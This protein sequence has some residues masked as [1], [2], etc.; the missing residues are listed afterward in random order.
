MTW[1]ELPGL[2]VS[3]SREL[4]HVDSSDGTPVPPL[5]F[6][7]VALL[8]HYFRVMMDRGHSVPSF[9]HLPFFFV[10]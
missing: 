8:I 6:A 4:Q 5:S 7:A 3:P 1:M 9:S 2:L 10:R